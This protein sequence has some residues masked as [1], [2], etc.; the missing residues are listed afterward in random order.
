MD[1]VRE[2][3]ARSFRP[4]AMTL[5][6]R[7]RRLTF[8][9]HV[10][11]SL[12][13]FGAALAF[14]AIAAIG[15]TADREVTVRGAYLVMAPT[16]WLVLVPLA[17]VSLI[18]GAALSLFTPWGLF[19]HY[20]VV[21]KLAITV[22]ATVMLLVYMETFREMAAVAA[23]P[24]VDIAAVRNASPFVHAFLALVLLGLATI[25]GIYK[26]FGLTPHGARALGRADERPTGRGAPLLLLLLL[27]VAIVFVLLHFASDGH[28]GHGLHH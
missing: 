22:F 5:T 19:R 12:G 8:T 28:G 7:L 17:H 2:G 9:T 4:S 1:R 18:S 27:A 23:D 25:L 21:M 14:L 6:P 20:W 3:A 11:S 10:T 26:P 15:L 16:A 24:V 13:W